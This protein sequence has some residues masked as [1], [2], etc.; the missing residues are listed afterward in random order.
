MRR[1]LP[2]VPNDAPSLCVVELAVVADVD[3]LLDVV[4]GVVD[5]LLDELAEL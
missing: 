2:N 1:S 5:V 3:V 4:A